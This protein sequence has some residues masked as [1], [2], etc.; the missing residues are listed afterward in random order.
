MFAG[1][2]EEKNVVTENA[3]LSGNKHKR[4][5]RQKLRIDDSVLRSS[6]YFILVLH[7]VVLVTT[8]GIRLQNTQLSVTAG[9]TA[10]RGLLS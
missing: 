3:G 2:S 7:P 9:L 4:S 5:N 6:F 1:S 10:S 8:S